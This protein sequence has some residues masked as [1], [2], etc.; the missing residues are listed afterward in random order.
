MSDLLLGVLIL[1]AVANLL[2]LIFRRRGSGERALFTELDQSLRRSEILLEQ[3]SK[4]INTEFQRSR[5]ENSNISLENRKE[6]SR[7]LESFEKRFESSVKEFNELQ[8]QKF[9]DLLG[10]QLQQNRSVEERLEK[11]RE[12][13]EKQLKDIQSDNN[14]KLEKMR[15]TV[16]EKL[17]E[18]LKTRL[19]ESFKMVNDQLKRVY[20]GLGDMQKL[21]TGVGDLK[22]VLSNVKTRGILGEVQLEHI[23]EQFLSP[24][25]Y[26]KNAQIKP[27]STESV[28]FAVKLPGKDQEDRE[29]LLPI[30]SKFPVEDYQR[31]LEMY[32]S[33][34]DYTREEVQR[35]E[36][37]FISIV[38]KSARLIGEKYVQPPATT[39]F[40]L[41]FVP[42]EGLYAQ[43]LRITG[44]FEQLQREYGITV[45]GPSNLVAFLNSLQMGFR[46]LAVQRRSS[47]VWK[48][49]GAVKNEFGKFEVVLKKAQSQINQASG[50]IDNL[51]GTRTRQ[52][53]RKL[54][55]VE[56]LPNSQQGNLLAPPG[57]E[58]PDEEE[59]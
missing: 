30:D 33:I 56:D 9:D 50:N 44:L 8:K 1:L 10:R 51:V 43:I 27:G 55:D 24:E 59:E 54:K 45:V 16:D 49:L 25:Q 18:T 11:L 12:T 57:E 21:A 32:E 19:G 34:D 48:I 6:L 14:Q 26:I 13:V 47:E 35:G 58:E 38:R 22:K 52:I 3:L 17:Q 37:H 28:E 2:V 20:E 39:N 31:L 23:L 29:V 53:Q 36:N 41:M 5:E 4:N 40:A 42:T 7:S 15:Q 46:T